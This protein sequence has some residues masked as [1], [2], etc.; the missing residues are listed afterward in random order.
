MPERSK[1]KLPPFRLERFFARYECA[2]PHLLCA[3]DCEPLT[4]PEL[5]ALADDEARALWERL[6]LGYTESQGHSLLRQ[7]IAAL[8]PGLCADDVLVQRRSQRSAGLDG[9]ART[10]GVAGAQS[11][12]PTGESEPSGAP[13]RRT[14][15]SPLLGAAT[16][17]QCGAGEA[18]LRRCGELLCDAGRASGRVALAGRRAGLASPLRAAG[19]RP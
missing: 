3:S 14:C 17:R 2:V 4:L 9:A 19:L 11:S 10:R 15:R 12:Q 8:Y 1:P 13:Y 6:S 7:E 16:G 5:L 18:A